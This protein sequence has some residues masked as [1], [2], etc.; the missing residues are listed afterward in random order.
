MT[1]EGETLSS[2]CSGRYR[3]AITGQPLIDTLIQEA[4]QKELKYFEDKLV[5]KR[6][7]RS[8]ARQR[9]GKA[10]ISV[11]WVDVNKGDDIHPNYRSRLVAR[12]IKALD[13]SGDT[14]FAPAPPNEAVRFAIS[15]AATDFGS[16]RTPI[17]DPASE[18][19]MQLSFVDI[20][21]AYFNAPTDPNEPTY[22]D[23]PEEVDPKREMC[24][25][26]LRHM[27]GTRKAADGWQEEYSSLL[28]SRLG[29][30][31]GTASPC[32]FVN[33]ERNITCAVHG[34]DFTSSGPKSELDWFE[35]ALAEHYELKVGPR[36][37]P[38]VEDAKEATV[39]NRVVRWTDEGI[40]WEADPRQSEKLVKECGLEGSKPVATLGV[41]P[42]AEQ[43]STDQDLE[44]NLYTAFRG[45][46][47]RGNY[48]ATD[49][50][51]C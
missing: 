39:L 48:L 2:G 15:S 8:E 18:Q 5:W 24:G 7:P 47:A 36:L 50:P 32:V 26:L 40:E 46:A 35:S 27:Y 10:P 1:G 17:R 13:R 38:G 41:K 37:G 44:R 11:R 29:F 21:R 4:R 43:M 22:V 30:T 31:Q 42:T 16:G 28:V 25:L 49:K 6:R 9:T 23:L 34:D 33:K 19:R 45:T 20:C 51:D 12:Q 14:Y 3:D